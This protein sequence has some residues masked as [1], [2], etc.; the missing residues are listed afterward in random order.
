[1]EDSASRF[2]TPYGVIIHPSNWVV[3][4]EQQGRVLLRQAVAKNIP[5]WSYDQ[6][7][8]FW[9]IRDQWRLQ[10]LS[11]KD[12]T[13]TY[14]AS[15]AAGRGDLRWSVPVRFAGL[16]LASV[17]VDGEPVGFEP[18]IRYGAPVALIPLAQDSTECEIRASY[19]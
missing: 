3:F 1:M 2:H 18:V 4:S 9:E 17:R 11:W 10:D 5:I 7:C 13:L 6:W 14:R 12:G 16:T 8:D 15:G 19:Q